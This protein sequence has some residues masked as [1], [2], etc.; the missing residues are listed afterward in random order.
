MMLTRLVMVLLLIMLA[1]N[2][3]GAFNPVRLLVAPHGI[4]G[5]RPLWG[6]IQQTSLP[7]ARLQAAANQAYR[8]TGLQPLMGVLGGSVE[9]QGGDGNARVVRQAKAW[10]RDVVVKLRLC[11]FAEAVF[12]TSS[13]VRYVV[14]PAVTTDEVWREFLREVDHLVNHDRQEVGTTLLIAPH[15]MKEL[16]DFNDFCGW[17]EEMIEGDEILVDRV[18]VACFHPK[19]AFHGLDEEDVLNYEKRSPHPTINLLRADMVDEYIAMGK[20][21]GIAEHNERVLHKEGKDAVKA[22]FEATLALE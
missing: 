4:A 16:H 1:T 20:T 9:V 2:S 22:A 12:N 18:L 5:R 3:V 17:L 21:L 11:P 13:G 6:T 14:S 15:C 7:L 19:H 10:V 8:D